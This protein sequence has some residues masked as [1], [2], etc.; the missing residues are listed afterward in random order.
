MTLSKLIWAARSKTKRSELATRKV[1]K[2][3]GGRYAIHHVKYVSQY[4]DPE[5]QVLGLCGGCQLLVILSRHRSRKAAEKAAN[6]HHRG[7]A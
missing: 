4:M 3:E 1:W 5:W 2:S 7:K 6:K